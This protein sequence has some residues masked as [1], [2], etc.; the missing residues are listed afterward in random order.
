VTTYI[1]GTSRDGHRAVPSCRSGRAITVPRAGS[2]AQDTARGPSG[3]PEGTTGHRT[4]V[5]L[6]Q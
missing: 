4:K 5:V 2:M 6:G 1:N 3:R